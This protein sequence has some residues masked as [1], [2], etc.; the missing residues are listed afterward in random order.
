LVGRY[1]GQGNAA[2]I[3]EGTVNGA[4]RKFTY[5]VKFP[6]DASGN[7]FIPRLWA[8]RRVGYLL[9][10]IRL[11]GENTEVRDEVTE[12]ARKYSIVTPYTA[13]LI[14]EDETHR[15]VPMA[16]RSLQEF[17]R[18][19]NAR[20][21]AARAWSD[22]KDVR[23]GEKAVASARAGSFYRA[24]DAAAPAAAN[25]ALASRRALGLSGESSRA[26]AASPADKSKERLVQYSQQAQF[27]AGKSFFQNDKQWI[28]SAV[29]KHLKAKVVR[30]Q[31]G[32]AEYF[33]LVAQ[34]PNALPWLA[35]GR[36][37]QFV[38]DNTVYD[39]YE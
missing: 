24:A 29:Q 30:I 16:M 17:N 12:L 13:Y 1:S 31:F 39:I 20:T 27:V 6:D 23:N 8:T 22:F 11:H 37:V 36:N 5:K 18:D 2:V 4:A 25:G 7:E 26:S 19:G 15:N 33:N 34:K 9:D 35:L 14:L 32:S 38:L 28:D 10:E 21:E 3:V